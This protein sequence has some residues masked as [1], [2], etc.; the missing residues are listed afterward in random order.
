MI[1][2]DTTHPPSEPTPSVWIRK[3]AI[4]EAISASALLTATEAAVLRQIEEHMDNRTR[5]AFP[6]IDL[7]AWELKLDA[8]TVERA[9]ASAKA[10]KWLKWR[11]RAS[12]YRTNVYQITPVAGDARPK[13]SERFGL[14]PPSSS[15]QH[16]R[17]E[18]P[19][20]PDPTPGSN[21]G[22]AL[23]L[24]ILDPRSPDPTP[25]YLLR[26]STDPI[27]TTTPTRAP[28]PA[29]VRESKPETSPPPPPPPTDPSPG[30]TA[31]P[32]ARRSVSTPIELVDA[33]DCAAVERMIRSY[34]IF[35]R[36]EAADTIAKPGTLGRI[37]D[38]FA[39]RVI[40]TGVPSAIACEAVSSSARN[41]DADALTRAEPPQMISVARCLRKH[42]DVAVNSWK[43]RPATAPSASAPRPSSPGGGASPHTPARPL[44]GAPVAP[45][46]E[47]AATV[48][49]LFGDAWTA[50][51]REPYSASRADGNA[52]ERFAAEAR[53][54]VAAAPPGAFTVE[55]YVRHCLAIAFADQSL[56]RK[57]F[58]LALIVANLGTYSV[59]RARPAAPPP[60]PAHEEPHA[61]RPVQP[62]PEEMAQMRAEA[63]AKALR[64]DFR[65]V[66]RRV[67]QDGPKP[68]PLP[69]A[70]APAPIALPDFEGDSI[71]SILAERDPR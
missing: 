16:G 59:P 11:P 34:S 17:P 27:P 71:A 31:R 48:L 13:P 9:L 65:R 55:A 40:S 10:K 43:S 39:S 41:L 23:A 46:S 22:G 45:A 32:N 14:V 62:T 37:A 64:G 56:A 54:K 57:R 66:V 63:D 3:R 36:A 67:V 4:L 8:R 42:F 70:P 7:L 38:D 53:D 47:D 1:P 26:G 60:P 20:L 35:V 28:E 30:T 21:P 44:P 29:R 68:P 33:T 19:T 69:R 18:L 49:R 58:P 15:S 52:A 2:P 50:A 24:P 6:G 12:V 25:P 5:E 51:V 61:P